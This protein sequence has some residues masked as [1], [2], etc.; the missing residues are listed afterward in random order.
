[1]TDAARE[2]RVTMVSLDPRHPGGIVGVVDS[3][4]EAGLGELVELT[5]IHTSAMNDPLPAKIGQA[6]RAFL[7]L[8]MSLF[9][10]H[11]PDVVHLHSSTGGSLLPQ[12]RPLV[13]L[14]ERPAFPTSPRCTRARSRP[15]SR[16]RRSTGA[17]PESLFSRAA[18]VIVLGERWR[19]Q[20]PRS[21]RTGSRSCQRDLE[22]R[23]RGARESARSARG[24]LPPSA[25]PV[26]LFYG[27]WAP[28]KGL[29]RLGRVLRRSRARRLRAARLRQRRPAL[30]RGRAS[31]RAGAVIDRR[32]ARRRAQGGRA[33]PRGGADS[34][35]PAPRA[36]RSPWSRRAR[37]A[38]R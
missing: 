20:R 5:E 6:A 2:M 24:S 15:G 36:S 30:A 13:A 12:A 9:G 26:L 7:R 11:R 37:R 8:A 23:G 17:P 21:A 35:R 10:G 4:R 33:R 28:V 19:E 3:W 25:P 16:P 1:M 14:L 27:R 22:R 34:P 18:T 32:L 31:R 29:D 38:R